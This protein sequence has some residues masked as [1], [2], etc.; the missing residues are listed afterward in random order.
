MCSSQELFEVFT[1]FAVFVFVQASNTQSCKELLFRLTAA[2][3]DVMRT[4]GLNYEF[5]FSQNT[6]IWFLCKS[7]HNTKLSYLHFNQ[8]LGI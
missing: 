1:H 6:I 5:A 4:N 2:H 7:K 3:V 8:N